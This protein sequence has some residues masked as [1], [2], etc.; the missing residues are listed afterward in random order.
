MP[1]PKSFQ[2]FNYY[3]QAL[4]TK[5]LDLSADTFKVMLTNSAPNPAT[6][7]QKSDLTDISAGFGYSAGGPAMTISAA[8]L[9]SNVWTTKLAD[10]LLTASGGAIG[11]FRYAVL[12]DDTSTNKILCGFWDYGSS[13]TLNDGEN[14]SLDFDDTNGVLTVTAS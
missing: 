13:Q 14:L 4:A 12:Y 6:H 7:T 1:T 3:A 5:Q 10:Y 11:P 9:A 2:K 8:A